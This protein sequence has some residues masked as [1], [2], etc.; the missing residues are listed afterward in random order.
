MLDAPTVPVIPQS[1][2]AGA[3]GGFPVT[4]DLSP[5]ALIIVLLLAG[6]F[7]ATI[8]VIMVYHWR[9]F[10][11]E[12]MVFDRVERWYFRVSAVLLAVSLFFIWA[13]V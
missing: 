1:D 4:L 3:L 7:F 13:A 11:Y 12:K 6:L 8:S 9:R 10:P 5:I 2:L